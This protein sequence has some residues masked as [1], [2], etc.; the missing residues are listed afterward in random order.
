M[1]QVSEKQISV[2]INLDTRTGFQNSLT[3]QHEFAHENCMPGVRSIDFLMEGVENKI[4]FFDGYE[5]Q[6][7]LHIDIHNRIPQEVRDWLD[8]QLDC[9]RLANVTFFRHTDQI[10]GGYDPHWNDYSY[11]NACALARTKYIAHFDADMAAFNNDSGLVQTW[12][13][14]VDRGEIDWISY[15]SKWSPVAV[16]DPSFDYRWVSTRFFFGKT[17]NLD[18][19][20]MKKCFYNDYLFTKYGDRQRKNPWFEH[21]LGIISGSRVFYPPIEMER[22]L[23]FSWYN[24]RRGLYAE[25]NG[26]THAEKINWVNSRGGISYPCDVNGE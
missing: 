19:T 7:S 25:L 12:I 2:I 21:V 17:A 22:Y 11:L 24:Y 14:M 6:T 20:E 16:D 15:P 10:N 3:R 8:N 26:K 4:R 9:H 1:D 23:I 5:I 18:Y 13:D